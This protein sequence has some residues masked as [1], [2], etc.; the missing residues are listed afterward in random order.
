MLGPMPPDSVRVLTSSD[1]VLIVWPIRVSIP[2]ETRGGSRVL[3]AK[4]I[5]EM[6]RLATVVVA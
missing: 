3:G 6:K 5:D 2:L 4:G 1:R